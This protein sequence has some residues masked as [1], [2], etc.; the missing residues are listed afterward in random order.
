MMLAG[1]VIL[2]TAVYFIGFKVEEKITVPAQEE[3]SAA[4]PTNPEAAKTIVIEEP[5]H[6]SGVQTGTTEP[7]TASGVAEVLIEI[8]FFNPAE[9]KVP[10]GTTVRWTNDDTRAHKLV[11]YDRTSYGERMQPGATYEFTFTEKGTY[12]Y[13]D[14]VFPKTFKGAI[15]VE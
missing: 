8:N 11:A 4:E 6:P 10:I 12:A 1:A 7:E 14:A 3:P 2:L 9:L 5:A 15:I 13:F